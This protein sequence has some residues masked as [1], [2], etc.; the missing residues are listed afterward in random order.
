MRGRV[1]I[2]RAAQ[3]SLLLAACSAPDGGSTSV[4]GTGDSSESS[5]SEGQAIG[6]ETES[7]D[8]STETGEACTGE[9]CTSILTL[10]FTHS[11]PLLDGPHRF[12]IVTPLYDLTCS[13][14]ASESGDKTCFGY[15]FAD[16][17]WTPELVTVVLTNA[18]FAADDNPEGV[19][20]ES[21]NVEVERG[22]EL[23]YAAEL[24]V[25]PGEP[26]QPDPCGPSCWD[27]SVSATIE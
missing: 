13:V 26:L 14:E 22:D 3:A 24:P 27:A 12:Y 4:A 15:A 9:T 19:P 8:T 17:S 21:V 10:T 1:S 5:D 18:F 2:H 23:L 11:L 25:E 16:L 20:F 7:G 6:S